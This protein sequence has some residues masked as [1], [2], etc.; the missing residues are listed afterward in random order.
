MRFRIGS[1]AVDE[2]LHVDEYS[3]CMRGSHR[4]GLLLTA[5]DSYR[6]G[7]KSRGYQGLN[8][9]L[10]LSFYRRSPGGEGAL[11][12]SAAMWIVAVAAARLPVVARMVTS[13]AVWPARNSSPA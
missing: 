10:V 6:R 4:R 11:H 12:M 7:L 13:P 9:R 8:G 3:R 2:V 1:R 5:A